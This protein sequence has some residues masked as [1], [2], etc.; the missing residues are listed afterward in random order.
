MQ[1]IV[2]R[3]LFLVPFLW[4]F[5]SSCFADQESLVDLKLNEIELQVEY[6]DTVELRNKGLMF[7][8]TLCEDCGMLFKFERSRH[9]SMWMK[10][11]FV[12][13]DIAFIRADGVIVDIKQM[14]PHDLTPIGSS[15]PVLYAL[16]M[17]QNWFSRHQVEVGDSLELIRSQ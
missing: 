7:R 13:L 1:K 14:T 12:A 16:E 3:P 8:K 15:Q 6:A 2:S 9:A 5:I 4:L 17:N 10:N 11:T